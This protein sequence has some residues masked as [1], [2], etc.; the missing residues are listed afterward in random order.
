MSRKLILMFVATIVLSVGLS[1]TVFTYWMSRPESLMR[2]FYAGEMATVVSPTLVKKYIDEK[3]PNYILV[4]LRSQ[5]EYEKE[6]IKS[7][8]N[9]P[10][11][12][13]NTEQLVAAFAKLDQSKE[14]IVH[15]YS[16]YCTLGSQVGRAL[17]EH[18]IY[19]KEMTSGWSEW[20]YHW[21]LPN[22]GA[23]KE[24]NANYIESGKADPATTP[25]IPCTEGEFGC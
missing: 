1:F 19:V 14:I 24:D 25:I 6:H 10:A 20:R 13:M 9:I 5:G 16:A 12:S 7:A 21:D 23:A 4:D 11:T 22:G 18:G 15:C 17:S 3:N 2:H 8:L